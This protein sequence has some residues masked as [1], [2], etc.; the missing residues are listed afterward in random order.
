MAV[1]ENMKTV[2]II[3]PVYNSEQTLSKCLDSV[4]SSTY[5]DIEVLLLDDGSKD[6]S[7]SICRKY[8]EKDS[9]VRVF[10]HDNHGVSYTRNRGL[11]EATGE[12]IMFVDSDDTISPT[13]VEAYAEAIEISEADMVIGGMTEI[14]V[15]G[16]YDERNP[17]VTGNIEVKIWEY[18]SDGKLNVFGYIPNKIY[19]K[20]LVENV[21]FDEKMT[22][23]EDM[24]F[25]IRISE[26]A[27]KIFAFK[28][29]GYYYY[30]VPSKRKT[31]YLGLINNQVRILNNL[32]KSSTPKQSSVSQLSER[33]VELLYTY[34]RENASENDWGKKYLYISQK[35][36]V[37]KY[38]S[39]CNV[40]ALKKIVFFL[41]RNKYV[42]FAHFLVCTELLPHKMLQKKI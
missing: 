37:K 23:Q 11:D 36:D 32:E 25:A 20:N 42:G 13:W 40:S 8:A 35:Y 17:Q 22:V 2:S 29:T 5:M 19:K 27:S 6:N 14:D 4:L 41:I 30:Y 21:R 33:I 16:C 3:I 18:I 26:T 28:E 15:N 9:R 10:H 39:Y 24:D 34:V 1:S 7:L 38:I 12:Y 31:D